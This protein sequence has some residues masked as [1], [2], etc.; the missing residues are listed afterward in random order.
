MRALSLL[1]A[2]ILGFATSQIPALADCQCL[3]NG[4]KFEQGQVA[5]LKLPTGF[6]LARCGKVLNNSSWQKLRDECP[7][8]ALDKA[9]P[10]FWQSIA[11]LNA[12]TTR[13]SHAR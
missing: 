2:T 8:S 9:K 6:Q 11:V 7:S 12:S 1:L 5:C 13:A 10:A 4:R 3:A